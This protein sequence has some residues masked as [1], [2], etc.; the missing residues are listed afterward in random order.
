MPDE[1]VVQIQ[2]TRQQDW[3]W[4]LKFNLDDVLIDLPVTWPNWRADKYIIVIIESHNHWDI[5]IE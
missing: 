4:A 3:F 2:K 1:G 5:D